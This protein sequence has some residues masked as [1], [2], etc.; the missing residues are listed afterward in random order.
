[1]PFSLKDIIE[2]VDDQHEDEEDERPRDCE[3]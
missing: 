2:E 3:A 1:M